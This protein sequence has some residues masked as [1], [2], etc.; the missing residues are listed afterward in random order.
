MGI[1]INKALKNMNLFRKVLEKN[2]SLFHKIINNPTGTHSEFNQVN[3]IG[4]G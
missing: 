1:D 3:N 2:Y 4:Y